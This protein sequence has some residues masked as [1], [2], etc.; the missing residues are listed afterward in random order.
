MLAFCRR[1]HELRAHKPADDKRKTS[2]VQ[3]GVNG[4][5]FDKLTARF[6][7]FSLSLIHI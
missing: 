2:N 7:R 6:D 5:F 3:I 1:K 4:V